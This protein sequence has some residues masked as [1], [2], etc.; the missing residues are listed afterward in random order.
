MPQKQK[1]WA[2]SNL[3][4]RPGFHTTA[5][6]A[7]K[8]TV[9][10]WGHGSVSGD[11]EIVISDCD[12]K[13]QLDLTDATEL[14]YMNSLY[15]IDTLIRVLTTFRADYIKAHEYRLVLQKKLDKKKKKK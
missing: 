13:I 9:E 8:A 3:L 10:K 4:N 5:A 15:K 6:I 2:I 11:G 7:C 1:S 14:E 12:R